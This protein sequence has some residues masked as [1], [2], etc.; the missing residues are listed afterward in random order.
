MQGDVRA[1]ADLADCYNSGHGVG[2][3]NRD[4]AIEVTRRARALLDARGRLR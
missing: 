1:Q 3:T 2:Q 4:K